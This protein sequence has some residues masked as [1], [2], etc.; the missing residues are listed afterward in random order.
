MD[1]PIDCVIEASLDY[2]A[3]TQHVTKPK[4][5]CHYIK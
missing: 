2:T 5:H 4:T 3:H 1:R